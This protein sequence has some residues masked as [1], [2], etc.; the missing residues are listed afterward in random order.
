MPF[1]RRNH[2]RSK[3]NQG[4]TRPVNC[5][6]CNRMVPKDKCIKKFTVKDIIDASS[7]DDISSVQVYE[8]FIIP[9][10]YNKLTYCISC[11]IHARIV[12]GRGRED[13]KIRNTRKVFEVKKDDKETKEAKEV[14]A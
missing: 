13:R 3:M 14:N 12:R 6:N 4:H 9:K 2:G 5:S 10:T 7:K 8:K 1:K 11:A